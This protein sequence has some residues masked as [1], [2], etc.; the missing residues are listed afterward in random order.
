MVGECS[1]PTVVSNLPTSIR[2]ILPVPI[3]MS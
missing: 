2:A 3:S 1:I